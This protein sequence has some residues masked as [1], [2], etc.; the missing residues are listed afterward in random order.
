MTSRRTLPATSDQVPYP[1]RAIITM[2]TDDIT[3]AWSSVNAS[4]PKAFSATVL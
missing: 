3:A 4:F 1:L 2:T